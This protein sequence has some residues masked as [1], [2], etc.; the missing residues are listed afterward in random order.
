M[1]ARYGANLPIL[2]EWPANFSLS[3]GG[4]RVKLSFGAGNAI[5]DFRYD[6]AEPWPVSTDGEGF[7]LVAGAPE[8]I[9][10]E[11]YNDASSWRASLS[12]GGSPGASEGDGGPDPEPSAFADWLASRGL[13][14][15]NG[16]PDQ[17]GIT[18]FGS[19]AMAI[20]LLGDGETS[21][22]ALPSLESDTNTLRV[23]RRASGVTAT[24]EW[25][26]NLQTW[27]TSEM[28]PTAPVTNADSSVTIEFPLGQETDRFWR[29]RF[30]EAP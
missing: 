6:D 7:S 14:D 11:A 19:Y 26:D 4:E 18:H 16:D 20:D 15:P 21:S 22:M 30:S 9:A 28:A 3:N 8:T 24:L 5:L 1:E 27:I 29:I 17:D 10:G 25:S 2:G 13:T 23:R 12:M